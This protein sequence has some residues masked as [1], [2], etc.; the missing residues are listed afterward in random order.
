M[1][2]NI[3]ATTDKTFAI[4]FYNFITFNF[5]VYK[6]FLKFLHLA[7]SFQIKNKKIIQVTQIT[8]YLMETMQKDKTKNRFKCHYSISI[9][10][11]K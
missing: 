3:S 7:I 8:V 9:F 5:S 10:I 4:F 1:E 2:W 6:R 11:T